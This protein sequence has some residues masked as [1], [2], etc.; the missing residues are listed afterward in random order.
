MGHK[1]DND[2]E[3]EL[4]EQGGHSNYTYILLFLGGLAAGVALGMYL[5]SKQGKK[6]RKQ[7]KRKMSALEAEIED[8][9]TAAMDQINDL[10]EKGG[11]KP[12]ANADEDDEDGEDGNTK[13]A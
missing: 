10:A 7:V 8:K 6:I 13:K 2:E 12:N 5:N 1:H 9:V 11:F 4:H 3:E